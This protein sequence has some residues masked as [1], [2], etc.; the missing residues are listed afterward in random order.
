[1]R[2]SPWVMILVITLMLVDGWMRP[3]AA[4]MTRRVDREPGVVA[5]APRP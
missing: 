5:A 2:L 4:A 3:A 1:M